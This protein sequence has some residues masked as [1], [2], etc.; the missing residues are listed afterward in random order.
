MGRAPLGFPSSFALRRY[1]R[2]TSR[3]GPGHRS[4][5]LELRDH[6]RLILQ[7]GSSLV[8]CDRR[9]TVHLSSELGGAAYARSVTRATAPGACSPG[10]SQVIGKR[11]RDRVVCRTGW[12]QSGFTRGHDFLDPP[13]GLRPAPI[14]GDRVD[15]GPLFVCCAASSGQRRSST[16]GRTRHR[17]HALPIATPIASTIA[18]PRVTTTSEERKLT[19]RNRCR[20]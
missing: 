14:L 13:D 8:A 2:R 9:R 7:S 6:I 16:A 4:T 1:R 11:H 12:G 19:C 3:A 5:D 18:P 10:T 15:V 20:T 17:A